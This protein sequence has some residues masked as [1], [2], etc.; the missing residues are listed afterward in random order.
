MVLIFNLCAWFIPLYGCPMALV[1]IGLCYFGMKSPK[2]KTFAIIG[3]V[4]S[5][6]GLIATL[7]NGALGANMAINAK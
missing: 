7:I 1:G 5:V 2:Y 3:L 6:L 4:I